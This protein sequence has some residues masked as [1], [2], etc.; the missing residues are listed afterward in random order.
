MYGKLR[1]VDIDADSVL[2]T[3]A[4]K[5]PDDIALLPALVPL[6]YITYSVLDDTAYANCMIVYFFN[7][8]IWF[9]KPGLLCEFGRY[10][11]RYIFEYDAL[12]SKTDLQPTEYISDDYGLEPEIEEDGMYDD[13]D[14]AD[15]IKTNIGFVD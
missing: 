11:V 5:Y 3:I 9:N 6:D 8:L 14:M 10:F 13:M 7:L 15:N 12:F 2:K 1:R 4:N